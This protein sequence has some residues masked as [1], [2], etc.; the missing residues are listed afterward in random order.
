MAPLCGHSTHPSAFV[1]QEARRQALPSADP[2]ELVA[3]LM[4]THDA[5]HPGEPLY[6]REA[7]AA[8]GVEADHVKVWQ[9]VG[10]LRRHGLVMSGKPREPGYRIEDWTW[11][12]RR[13]RSTVRQE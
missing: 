8:H 5:L 7:L 3:G 11:E 13:V 10:K 4:L 1:T 6:V 12:A 2:L 9:T